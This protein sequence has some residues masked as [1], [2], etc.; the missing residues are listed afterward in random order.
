MKSKKEIKD[1]AKL[2]DS[3]TTEERAEELTA[4]GFTPE[5]VA[6]V[7]KLVVGEQPQATPPAKNEKK[8]GN[9]KEKSS[10]PKFEEWRLARIDGKLE[11]AKKVKTVKISQE[12][13][14][15]L[16]AHEENSLVRYVKVEN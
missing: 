14:D 11:Q 6:E 12:R 10:H 2:F 13:A 9:D 15:R 8:Q 16:N 4:L 7:E 3:I 1:A 5:E